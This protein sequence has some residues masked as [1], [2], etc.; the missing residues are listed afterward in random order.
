MRKVAPSA[1]N[2][3]TLLI[4]AESA[5][6]VEGDAKLPPVN[7]HSFSAQFNEGGKL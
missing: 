3:E 2:R 6:G 4:A 1:L 7:T 5:Y